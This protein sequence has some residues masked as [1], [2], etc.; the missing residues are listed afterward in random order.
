MPTVLRATLGDQPLGT[1][2]GTVVAVL[3]VAWA[4]LFW[5]TLLW[6]RPIT[7]RRLTVRL[8]MVTT[9]SGGIIGRQLGW[10]AVTTPIAATVVGLTLA[11]WL[12]ATSVLDARWFDHGPLYGDK[13][14]QK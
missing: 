5:V 7:W 2:D 10:D 4:G 9:W 6:Q 1:V 11:F 14:R 8:L 12:C 13:T 3:I